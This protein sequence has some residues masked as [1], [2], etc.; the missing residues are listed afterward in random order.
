MKRRKDGRFQT[1]VYVG[2]VDGKKKTVP[3]YGRTQKECKEK[4]A[5]LKAKI[6]KGVNI[7]ADRQT[8]AEWVSAWKEAKK[9][10]KSEHQQA[11]DVI[12][13]SHF[14]S[15]ARVPLNKLQIADFQNI[16]NDLHLE[17]PTTGRPTA[18]SS[19]IKFRSVASQVFE[20]AIENRAVDFNPLKFVKIPHNS[21]QK[22]RRALTEQ[23]QGWIESFEHRAQLPAMIMLYSGLRLAEC[24]ALQWAD[25]DLDGG[26]IDVHKTLVMTPPA[27]IKPGAK[28]EA[29]VRVVDIPQ[30]LID[31]LRPLRGQPF[32]YICVNTRGELYNKT[33]WR[34]LWNSYL[35]DLNFKYGD[36][37]LF[38]NKPKSKYQPEGVPM[39]IDRFTAHYL[40]HTHT[41]NLFDAGCDVVYV[42][43]QLGHK[44]IKTTLSIYTHLSEKNRSANKK[45][46]DAMFEA[47]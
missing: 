6:G 28:T 4:A 31:Y 10:V 43:D 21:P 41:T 37:S 45:R 3:V 40:R 13:L 38:L 22:E 12:Y 29:G 11:A 18:K 30:K 16:I 34:N 36:F 27:H 44:D 1:S 5:A 25:V 15:L 9:F 39:V 47:S 26:T 42:K 33:S 20:Y 23:E 35:T 19:L 17:N 8:W 2:M 24:L 7:I 14:D 32:D 46:L